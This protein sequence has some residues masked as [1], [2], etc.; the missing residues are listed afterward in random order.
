MRRSRVSKGAE[1]LI[2]DCAINVALCL[3]PWG[4]LLNCG[5]RLLAYKENIEEAATTIFLKDGSLP[6]VKGSKSRKGGDK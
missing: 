4:P 3:L 1:A 5:R 6:V 2:P